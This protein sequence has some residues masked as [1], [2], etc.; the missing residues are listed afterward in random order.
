MPNVNQTPE[1]AARERIDGMLSKS[2]WVVQD[3]KKIDFSAGL[4]VAVREYQTDVGPA[5]YV[6]FVDKKP[7]GVVE[8]KPEDWGEKITT[9]EEQSAAYAAARLKWVNNQEP[10]PFVYESTGVLTRFTDGRDPRPRSREVFGFPRPDTVQ[11]WRAQPAIRME[12]FEKG[13]AVS[14]RYRN[15]RIGEFLKELDLAEGRSTGVPKILRAMRGNGSPAA[16]FE[17]DEDR[18]WFLVRLPVH[19]RVRLE[20]TEQDTPQDTE[21]ETEQV[22][23]HDTGQVTGQVEQLVVAL[24]GE[25]SRAELQAAL[26]LT[27][28]DYFTAAYL[29]PALEAGLIEIMSMSSAMTR[30]SSW[31]NIGLGQMTFLQNTTAGCWRQGVRFSG[32]RWIRRNDGSSAALSER[33]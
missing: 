20:P 5:D 23:A 25:L 30:S 11:D 24:T 14:R 17:S 8:A 3:K 22:T 31:G 7:V 2:G 33:K 26:S 16:V 21:H 12:D 19:E 32:A 18:T 15:R 1:Q 10:L 13:Q 28:R 9:V 29:C 4:G 27:H 6:L